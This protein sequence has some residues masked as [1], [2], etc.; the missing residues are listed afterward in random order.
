[1]KTLHLQV[2]LI[3]STCFIMDASA[4]GACMRKKPGTA[5][6][7]K[8]IALNNDLAV[9]NALGA[10]VLL[11]ASATMATAEDIKS[12]DKVANDHSGKERSQNS[13]GATAIDEIEKIVDAPPIPKE[14]KWTLV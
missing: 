6:I 5:P 3:L 7:S 8:D 14:I 1:M 2:G 11:P 9:K 13:S 12:I 4:A 10:S